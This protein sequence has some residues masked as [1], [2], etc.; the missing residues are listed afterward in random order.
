VGH[1]PPLQ[2]PHHKAKDAG[3]DAACPAETQFAASPR[4]CHDWI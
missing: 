1:A 3:K 4:L 2:N